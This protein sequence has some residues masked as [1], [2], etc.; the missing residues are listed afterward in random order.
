MGLWPRVAFPTGSPIVRSRY[1]LPEFTGVSDFT[2]RKA[3]AVQ[4]SVWLAYMNVV[5]DE[6]L[7]EVQKQTNCVIH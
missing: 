1:E 2:S 3:P 5:E 6:L 7:A 4:G